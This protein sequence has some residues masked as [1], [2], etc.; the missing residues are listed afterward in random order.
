MLLHVLLGTAWVHGV[1][2]SD[3]WGYPFL[4]MTGFVGVFLAVTG[5]T[6]QEWWYLSLVYFLEA[7]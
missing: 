2:V 4:V 7:N 6:E 3:F 1:F 5:L